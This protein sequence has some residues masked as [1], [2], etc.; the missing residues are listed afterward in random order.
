M[1]AVCRG[2][3]FD[4]RVAPIGD[5]DSNACQEG[6]RD[7]LLLVEGSV[8][9]ARGEGIVAGIPCQSVRLRLPVGSMVKRYLGSAAACGGCHCSLDLELLYAVV[10]H[11][12]PMASVEPLVTSS[13][14]KEP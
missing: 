8:G 11:N 13:F 9:E 14:P 10:V 12:R 1:T 5:Y 3:Y 2:L 7:P 4:C 6:R